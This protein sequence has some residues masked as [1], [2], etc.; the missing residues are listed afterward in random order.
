MYKYE[1][2]RI[3]NISAFIEFL[4]S[5]S[6]VISHNCFCELYHLTMPT[7][8]EQISNKPNANSSSVKQ[9]MVF[10]PVLLNIIT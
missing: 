1:I 6:T 8:V 4:M 7:I 5:F 9:L 2:E 10:I 3:G